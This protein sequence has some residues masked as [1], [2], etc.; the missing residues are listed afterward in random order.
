MNTSYGFQ[1]G[2]RY[3][4]G[5]YYS[6]GINS[7]PYK[8]L[9]KPNNQLLMMRRPSMMNQSPKPQNNQQSNQLLLVDYH[10]Y[11]RPGAFVSL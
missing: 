5:L 8:T 3:I 1:Y 4:Y 6:C 10:Q 9:Y 11:S 7:M 2:M